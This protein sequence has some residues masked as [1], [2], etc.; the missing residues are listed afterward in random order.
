MFLFWIRTSVKIVKDWCVNVASNQHKM[1]EVSQRIRADANQLAAAK[2]S[3][4]NLI[5]F[6]DCFDITTINKVVHREVWS[7]YNRVCISL[8]W[9]AQ[10]ENVLVSWH[11]TTFSNAEVLT[12]RQSAFV[13]ENNFKTHIFLSSLV[14]WKS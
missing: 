14:W 10:V 6:L 13:T 7:F 1:H 2:W 3:K 5:C 4:R 12:C 11:V 8:Q 9:D